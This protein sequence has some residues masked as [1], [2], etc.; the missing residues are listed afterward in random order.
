MSAPNPDLTRAGALPSDAEETIQAIHQGKVDAIVVEG[1]DGPR[2]VVLPGADE[3]Y[4]VLVERMSDGALTLDPDGAILYANRRLGELTGQPAESLVGRQFACLFAGEAPRCGDNI[5]VAARLNGASGNIPV[6]VWTSPIAIGGITATLMTITDLSVH[7][8]AEEVASAERFARSIL[9]QA[10]D[11]VVVLS[12]DGRITHASFMAEQIALQPPVGC[13]FSD[14]FPVDA[15]SSSQASTLAR[16]SRE[17]LNTMLATR[18]FHGV[19]VRLH[20][21]RLARRSFL[22]S[23]GP[24]LNDD[25]QSIGSIVT[26]TEI[27]ER[28]R[29]EEQQRILVAELNHRVKNILAIVQSVAGQTLRSSPSL[30]AFN[31]TFAGRIK[32]L[33]IAHDILTQTRWIGIGL[34]ELLAAVLAPYRGDARVALQGPPVM[35]PARVVTPLSMAIHELATNAS[36]YGALSGPRGTVSISWEV[37]HDGISE[38]EMT[39]SEQGGPKVERAGSSGFGTRLIQRVVA[40][41]LDGNVDLSFAPDGVCGVLRFPLKPDVVSTE[42]PGSATQND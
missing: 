5:A 3:P 14:A 9:E 7:V 4:R 20:N 38:V 30:N 27:T 1:P 15:E 12:P 40:Y 25:K 32:A 23:A 24:L 16:F 29:A 39:W 28:K 8:R 31:A 19:E 21:P 34:N 6:S 41:D 22:L 33:S 17:S 11:A 13:A 26:L 10:T 37:R 36:K 18:P 35:L 42:L 2:V